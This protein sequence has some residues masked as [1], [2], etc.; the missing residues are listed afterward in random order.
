MGSIEPVELLLRLGCAA[1]LGAVLGLDRELRGK[2]MGLRTL[3]LISMG[4][5]LFTLTA[6]ELVAIDGDPDNTGRILQ[7]VI[8]GIGVVGVGVILHQGRT[9]RLATTGAC[10][11]LI[12]GVGIAS[13]LGLYLLAAATT[14]ITLLVLV[15]FGFLERHVIGD[16][17]GGAQTP[18]DD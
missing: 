4:S 16:D 11:W 2:P 17:A 5:A 3:T 8:A 15:L 9:L 14:A 18:P 10:V 7:G 1:L 6:L 12:G 13:G